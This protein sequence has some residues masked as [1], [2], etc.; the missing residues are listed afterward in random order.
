MSCPHNC[1]AAA[2]RRSGRRCAAPR[3]PAARRAPR[4]RRGRSRARGRCRAPRSRRS[5]SNGC[6]EPRDVLRG[7]D[8]ALAR[9]GQLDLVAVARARGCAP[10]R[11]RARGAPRSRP[12][13]RPGARAAPRRRGRAPRP[14]CSW[15]STPAAAASPATVAAARRATA[16]RSTG[17][18]RRAPSVLT[19]SSE[20]PV[21]QL[22]GAVG[23]LDH[24]AR[25]LAQLL[26]A[27]VRVVERDLR[28]GA[29]DVSGVRSSCEALATKR[30]CASTEPSTRSSI[31][32]KATA[33]SC[34][35]SCGPDGRTRASSR[36]SEIRRSVATM[37]R[38]GASARPAA[39]QPTPS[40]TSAVPAIASAY[41]RP[42]CPSTRLAY[43]GG[44]VRSRWPREQP[45]AQRQQ[46]RRPGDQQP[47]VE[48]RQPQPDRRAEAHQTR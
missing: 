9:H 17:S 10:R 42:S 44:R 30:R 34:S 37:V 13:C 46:Q 39:S 27:R 23:R 48:E 21:E 20:Q 5:R 35:S 4:R 31:E 32:S 15:T 7:D 25:D 1:R 24:G 47:D 36:S 29:H 2:P 43:S 18:S 33:S 3:A 12:G 14:S 8:V 6:A 22:L 45:P 38:I 11:R 28:L 16:A 41:C 19:A 26:D 40:A